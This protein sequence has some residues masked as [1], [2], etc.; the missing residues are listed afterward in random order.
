MPVPKIDRGIIPR[1]CEEEI[2]MASIMGEEM[3]EQPADVELMATHL[4]R[5]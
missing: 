3:I 4:P 2:A 1:S 5:S